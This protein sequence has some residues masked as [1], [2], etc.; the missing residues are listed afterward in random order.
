MRI[1]VSV[2]GSI[3]VIIADAHPLFREGVR[4]T[5][6][7]SIDCEIVAECST[8]EEVLDAINADLPDIILWDISM[9]G[10]G[11]DMMQKLA[12]ACPKSRIVMLAVS[13]D[14]KEVLESLRFGA[15]GYILKDISGAEFST[16]IRS[17]QD[18]GVYIMPSL[19][20]SV[21]AEDRHQKYPEETTEAPLLS[22]REKV[23]L[24]LVAQGLSN[25]E[26]ASALALGERAVKTLMTR[27]FRK[28]NVRNR[29]EAAIKANS[30][31][32]DH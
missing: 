20:D 8:G 28:L 31:H 16:A 13:V 2:A 19:R 1:G 25:R 11:T 6:T 32:T 4:K 24:K 27:I 21:S 17:I 30:R 26:I 15:T 5:L 10:G 9:P 29:V 14:E 12:T 23:V 7:S 22:A 18:G 3:K